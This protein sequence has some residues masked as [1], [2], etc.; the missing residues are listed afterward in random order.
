MEQGRLSDLGLISITSQLLTEVMKAKSFQ[1]SV[2]T[3][4]ASAERQMEFTFK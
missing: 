4:F 1:D 2:I 3:K